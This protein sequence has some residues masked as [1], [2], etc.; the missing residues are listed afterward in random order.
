MP[1]TAALR[2]FAAALA[3][4]AFAAAASAPS[5]AGAMPADREVSRRVSLGGAC[6]HCQLQGKKLVGASLTAADFS[7]SD[8]RDADLRGAQVM[9][10]TF[11]DC[12]FS[13]ADLRG[14]SLARLP[15]APQHRDM[16]RLER[17]RAEGD[18]PVP[19]RRRRRAG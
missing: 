1:S 8:L 3:L 16:E 13:R 17:V 2:P 19:A 5:A 18:D 12:D 7:G 10:S 15:Y 11:S 9:A 14:A 4:A 6:R